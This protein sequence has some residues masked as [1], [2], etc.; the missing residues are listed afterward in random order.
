MS[1][2][3]YVNKLNN[4]SYSSALILDIE[5]VAISCN[6]QVVIIREVKGCVHYTLESELGFYIQVVAYF[7]ENG[8]YEIQAYI[9]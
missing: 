6:A 3:Q 4:I 8:I 2:F 9:N 5:A 7:N 1:I